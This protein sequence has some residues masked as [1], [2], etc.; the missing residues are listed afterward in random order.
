VH[1]LHIEHPIADF[2]SWSAAFNR[3]ADVRA[4]SGVCAHRIQQPVDDSHY[5]VIDLDF[6]TAP[7]AHAFLEFLQQKVWS[8]RASSPAL[9]GRPRTMILAPA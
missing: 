2:A 8:S 7:E 9:V 1:T 5:V 6:A 3:L 4:K